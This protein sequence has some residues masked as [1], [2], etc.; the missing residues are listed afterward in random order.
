MCSK[1][2]LAL[3]RNGPWN[4][5]V[6]AIVPSPPERAPVRVIGC[7]SQP[8]YRRTPPMIVT[9]FQRRPAA[10]NFSVERVFSAVRRALPPEVDCRLAVSRYQSQGLLGRVYNIFE[11]MGR[12]EGINHVTGDTTYLTVLLHKK[13]TIL[14]I[15][16]CGSMLRLKGWRR[17]F[18]RLCWLSLPVKRCAVVTVVS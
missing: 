2:I 4:R 12:Q 3:W 9:H 8:L 16:D 18:F 13:N 17:L 15:H 11:A 1:P 5:G 14:T 10:Q 7:A 6:A